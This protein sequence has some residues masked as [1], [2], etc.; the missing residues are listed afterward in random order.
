MQREVA[1]C[2]KM[3]LHHTSHAPVGKWTCDLD[4]TVAGDC[5]LFSLGSNGDATFEAAILERAQHC[6]VGCDRCQSYDDAVAGQP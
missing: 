3:P 4:Y 5:T 6:K 1:D 2:Q